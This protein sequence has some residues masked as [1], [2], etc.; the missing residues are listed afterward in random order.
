MNHR[1]EYYK[2]NSNHRGHESQGE[3]HP[4]PE[5]K[6]TPIPTPVLTPEAPPHYQIIMPDN[7]GTINIYIGE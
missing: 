1:G 4:T 3:Y 7:Q 2:P 5:P 6:W